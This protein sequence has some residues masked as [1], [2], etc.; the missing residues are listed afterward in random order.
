M[1]RKAAV[2]LLGH[3][4]AA[5]GMVQAVANAEILLVRRLVAS[6]AA[7]DLEHTSAG[8]DGFVGVVGV[9]QCTAG[10]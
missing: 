5:A 2:H 1:E 6:I 8:L 10:K 7:F 9:A 4:L 3:V